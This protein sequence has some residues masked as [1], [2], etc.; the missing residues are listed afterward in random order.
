MRQRAKRKAFLMGMAVATTLPIGATAKASGKVEPASHSYV[1]WQSA[2]LSVSGNR[3]DDPDVRKPSLFGR[4]G[5]LLAGSGYTAEGSSPYAQPR[6]WRMELLRNPVDAEQ[7][8]D[9]R[10]AKDKRFGVAFRLSF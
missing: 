9:A 8:G 10:P 1:G 4:L 3:L 5:N 2:Q 6:G 7:S